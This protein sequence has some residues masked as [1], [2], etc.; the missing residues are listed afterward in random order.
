MKLPIW[1]NGFYLSRLNTYQIDI[2]S[3]K[4]L[5]KKLRDKLK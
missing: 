3:D 4:K 2:F 5:Q 1:K